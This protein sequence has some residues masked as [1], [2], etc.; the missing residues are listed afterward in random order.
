[1]SRENLGTNCDALLHLIFCCLAL[2]T[3]YKAAEQH[4][5]L[6]Y[7]SCSLWL[8]SQDAVCTHICVLCMWE[9]CSALYI[10]SNPCETLHMYCSLYI[11]YSTY[12]RNLL[13]DQEL[14]L[15]IISLIVMTLMFDSWLM[16]IVMTLMFDSWL[17]L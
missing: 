16:N 10:Y 7:I 3:I 8:D 12:W 4:T 6:L 17:I 14:D 15:E 13:N 11:F 5:T 2:L 1:M 9:C